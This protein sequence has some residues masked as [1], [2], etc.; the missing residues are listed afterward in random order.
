MKEIFLED[1]MTKQGYLITMII[2][3]FELRLILIILRC[4]FKRKILEIEQW[5]SFPIRVRLSNRI[6]VFFVSGDS[7]LIRWQ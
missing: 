7:S 2:R 5:S 4:Y 6:I 3:W 1:S